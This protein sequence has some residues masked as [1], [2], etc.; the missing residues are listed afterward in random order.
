M[1][2]SINGIQTGIKTF[3]VCGTCAC[4]SQSPENKPYFLVHKDVATAF[5]RCDWCGRVT[6]KKREKISQRFS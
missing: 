1:S 4:E 6:T 3:Y 2:A 5:G